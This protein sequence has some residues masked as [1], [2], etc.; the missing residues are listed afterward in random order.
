MGKIDPKRAEFLAIME[1]FK[2]TSYMIHS[3]NSNHCWSNRAKKI[4]DFVK[5]RKKN[6]LKINK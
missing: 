5:Q 3:W 2:L 6:A 4:A 1:A